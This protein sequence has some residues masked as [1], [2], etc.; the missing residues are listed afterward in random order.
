M[1]CFRHA[2]IAVVFVGGL[3][4][5]ANVLAKEAA[6]PGKDKVAANCSR[7]GG[8]NLP[9]NGTT[10]GCVKSDGTIVMCGGV[11]PSHKNTCTIA[12]VAGSDR[13]SMGQRVTA[14]TRHP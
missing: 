4:A 11:K 3:S 2:L 8:I 6:S 10:Y 9:D 12:M 7:G 5:S 14:T 13:R 1:L